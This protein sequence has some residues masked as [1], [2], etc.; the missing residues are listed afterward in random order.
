M[1]CVDAKHRPEGLGSDVTG[2]GKATSGS[3]TDKLTREHRLT[4]DE[5]HLILN[6]KKEESLEQILA[7]SAKFSVS[8]FAFADE[9]WSNF[10]ALR[11]PVQTEFALGSN[12]S[13]KASNREACAGEVSLTLPPVKGCPG[14]GTYRSGAQAAE[15][16]IGTGTPTNTRICTTKSI[17]SPLTTLHRQPHVY[18]IPALITI[19]TRFLERDPVSGKG[20]SIINTRRMG[21]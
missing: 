14:E 16:V 20:R 8:F 1:S 3:L 7:V 2:V 4:L 19:M 11:A 10:V 15:H 5:A 13:C 21:G 6:A 9:W 17:A 12:H 18:D